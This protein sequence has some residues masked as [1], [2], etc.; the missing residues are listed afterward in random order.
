MLEITS[1]G[2]TQ[3]TKSALRD[4]VTPQDFGVPDAYA[5]QA[6]NYAKFMIAKKREHDDMILNAALAAGL[7]VHGRKIFTDSSYNKIDISET[8]HRF[9]NSIIESTKDD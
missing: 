8:L 9:A 2:I 6:I 4:N 5:E 7:H 3:M 1:N